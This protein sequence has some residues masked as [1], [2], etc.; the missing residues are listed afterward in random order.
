MSTKDAYKQ[1]IEAEL[2][3]A[4][5]QLAVFKARGKNLTADARIRHARQVDDLEQKA[6]ATRA[7]LK[8][9]DEAGEDTWELLKDGVEN[10]WGALQSALNDTVTN[11]KD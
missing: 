3:L 4:Q 8:E 9:L 5:A 6:D 7:K 11:F 10:I 1:K 2:E